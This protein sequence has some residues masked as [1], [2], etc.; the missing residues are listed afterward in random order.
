MYDFLTKPI[1]KKGMSTAELLH[2]YFPYDK[3]NMNCWYSFSKEMK[4]ILESGI[5][6]LELSIE[7]KYCNDVYIVSVEDIENE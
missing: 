6:A 1:T 7:G 2:D 4:P 5:H 3:S